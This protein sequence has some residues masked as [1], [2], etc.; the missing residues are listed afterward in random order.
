MGHSLYDFSHPCDHDEVREVL[1]AHASDSPVEY[2][3]FVRMKC[4]I[5]PKGRNINLKSAT[6]KVTHLTGRVVEGEPAPLTGEPQR[7]LV[8]IAE[9]IPHPSNIEVTLDSKT[10]LS[11]HAMDMKFTYCDE[12][13]VVFRISIF[14]T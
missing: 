4:T 8:L 7:Y 10:F 12:R 3:L 6:Y 11:R 9:P 13:W 14:R 5:T 2:N 1:A